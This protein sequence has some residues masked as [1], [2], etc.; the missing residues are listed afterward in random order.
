MANLPAIIQ[1]AIEQPPADAW[2]V[3]AGIAAFGS[4]LAAS[5]LAQCRILGMSTGSPH[6]L[7]FCAGF[8]TVCA[9]SMASH[10][11]SIAAHKY[12]KYGEKPF[13]GLDPWGSRSNAAFSFRED[14]VDLK[15]VQIPLHTVRM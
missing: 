6:P 10:H 8:A 14:H 5:T 2:S 9:A 1:S 15:F 7:P 12:V 3:L 4:T 13:S 11:A